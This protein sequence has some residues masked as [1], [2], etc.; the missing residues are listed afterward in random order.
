MKQKTEAHGSFLGYLY[1]S[2]YA[3]SLI[4][5]H[6]NDN[7]IAIEKFD[8]VIL[9]ENG[10]IVNATQVK[11][12]LDNSENLTT[13]SIDFWRTLA[14]WCYS[15]SSGNLRP[16]ETMLTLITTRNIAPTCK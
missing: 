5:E 10:K 7:E 12:H 8:D 15:F 4:L 3:L 2:Y 6:D 11:R 16:N 9:F 13:S 14:N 1:Q